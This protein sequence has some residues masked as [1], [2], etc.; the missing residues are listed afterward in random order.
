M[1]LIPGIFGVA[2]AGIDDALDTYKMEGR[3]AISNRL[4]DETATLLSGVVA[5]DE[6]DRNI[7]MA[8]DYTGDVLT[9]RAVALGHHPRNIGKVRRAGNYY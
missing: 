2:L 3:E 4:D 5:L 8:F 7:N 6:L 9:A 1:I